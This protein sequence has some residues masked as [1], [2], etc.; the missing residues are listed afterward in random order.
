MVSSGGIGRRESATTSCPS[1][2]SR[3]WSAE[4]IR[5]ETPDTTT[6]M[7]TLPRGEVY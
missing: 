3:A 4:P 1:A 7:Q 5:P 6:L 2:F